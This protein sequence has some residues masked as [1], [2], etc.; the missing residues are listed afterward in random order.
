MQVGARVLLGKSAL[1]GGGSIKGFYK[2][3]R[4]ARWCLRRQ[5][6]KGGEQP[7]EN[8]KGKDTRPIT[9]PSGFTPGGG[10]CWD[11][12]SLRTSC[13]PSTGRRGGLGYRAAQT[14][15]RKTLTLC[16]RTSARLRS[17]DTTVP[18]VAAGRRDPGEGRGEEGT[19]V[20]ALSPRGGRSLSRE[21]QV[22]ALDHSL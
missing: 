1:Q 17:T 5:K 15:A 3:K 19:Q 18:E 2:G 20:C 10:G 4:H 22:L 14:A 8:L 13:I 6:A 11:F 21:G 7:P 16:S 12:K 9:E